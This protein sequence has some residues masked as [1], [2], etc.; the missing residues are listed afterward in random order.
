MDSAC[1]Y[2]G[3]RPSAFGA[4]SLRLWRL[5]RSLWR[6]PPLL[7]L[8]YML[9]CTVLY[10][11][12]RRAPQATGYAPQATGDA[13]QATG[14]AIKGPGKAVRPERPPFQLGMV[15]VKLRN[16]FL[17]LRNVRSYEQLILVPLSLG[18][19]GTIKLGEYWYH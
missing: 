8:A 18:N 19:V 13:P 4:F 15:H 3:D 5:I 14:D 11:G 10:A 7:G 1:F 17:A 2:R 9:Y 6:L 16:R 12:S